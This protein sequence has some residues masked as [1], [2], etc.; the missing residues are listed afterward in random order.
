MERLG[1]QINNIDEGE[2]LAGRNQA[3]ILAIEDDNAPAPTLQAN[4]PM[5][6]TLMQSGFMLRRFHDLVK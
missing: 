2:L 6:W 3:L 1:D 4:G 5:H